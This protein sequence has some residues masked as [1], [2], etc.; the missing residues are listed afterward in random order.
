MTVI[1]GGRRSAAC[2]ST[3][4]MPATLIGHARPESPN[5]A[6]AIAWTATRQADIRRDGAGSIAHAAADAVD[7]LREPSIL[8]LIAP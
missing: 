6:A 1:G 7:E 8:R 4:A 2:T 3:A 5:D